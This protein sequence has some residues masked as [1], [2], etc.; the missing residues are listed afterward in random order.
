MRSGLG[1]AGSKAVIAD[2]MAI[3]WPLVRLDVLERDSPVLVVL[4]IVGLPLIHELR[5]PP[6]AGGTHQGLVVP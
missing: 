6:F 4:A 3:F 1:A 2:S 5:E